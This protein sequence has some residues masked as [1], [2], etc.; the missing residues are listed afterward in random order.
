MAKRIS[1]K[2]LKQD[3]FVDAAVDVG[4]WVEEHKSE[5]L[6]GTIGL[7]V[8]VLVVVGGI[9]WSRSRTQKTE[10]RI[11]VAITSYERALAAGDSGRTDLEAVLA[12]FEDASKAGGASGRLAEFYRGATLFHLGRGDEA[13]T[14]L[15][16][17]VA[18][19]SGEP[20]LEATAQAMLAR[21]YLAEG[22]ED[23]ATTVITAAL[24]S[25]NSILPQDQTLLELGRIHAAAGRDDEAQKA[26][27]RVLDDFPAST[28]ATEARQLLGS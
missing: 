5:L 21:V 9:S 18:S 16:G 23:E 26:W 27:Q 11:A 25:P 19:S 20:T 8:L 12:T 7:V 14:A 6:K 4:Q 3:E 28:A 17:V 2:E 10:Q 1:R 22:R 15:E 24:D 13:L